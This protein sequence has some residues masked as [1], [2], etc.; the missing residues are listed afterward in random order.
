MGTVLRKFSK[1]APGP[2]T[3]DEMD[4]IEAPALAQAALGP[5]HPIQK[6][7]QETAPEMGRPLPP[8]ALGVPEETP[9]LPA[10]RKQSVIGDLLDFAPSVAMSIGQLAGQGTAETRQMNNSMFRRATEGHEANQ[11]RYEAQQRANARNKQSQAQARANAERQAAIDS[12]NMEAKGLEIQGKKVGLEHQ[13]EA[14]DFTS[15]PNATFRET[16]KVSHPQ[17]WNSLSPE[18]QQTLRLKDAPA[19]ANSLAEVKRKQTVTDKVYVEDQKQQSELRNNTNLQP[20]WGGGGYSQSPAPG[21][22]QTPRQIV[23]QTYG[24]WEAAPAHIRGQA[25]LVQ[26]MNDSKHKDTP[27]AFQGLMDDIR[28]DRNNASTAEGKQA[29]AELAASRGAPPVG[30]EVA[31][32]GAYARTLQDAGGRKRIE[33]A[34]AAVAA[35]DAVRRMR[36]LR[37]KHGVDLFSSAA[38]TEFDTQRNILMGSLNATGNAGVLND[39]ERK[40]WQKL[41]SGMGPSIQDSQRFLGMGDPLAQQL[42]GLE[43]VLE[44]TVNVESGKIGLKHRGKTVPQGGKQA[45]KAASSPSAPSGGMLH[46]EDGSSLPDT[47]Q[48]RK[49]AEDDGLKFEV[50]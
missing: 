44:Q 17:V 50:Q 42:E 8:R 10:P 24:S 41:I 16:L 5:T 33:E 11:L 9:D 21:T 12:Q 7:V 2:L 37:A 13:A 26:R 28:S 22:P 49:L 25:D 30:F 36:E 18:Q 4:P 29:A 1:Q 3:E 35:R 43:N 27:T 20:V 23:E 38:K 6:Y 45:P 14:D 40:G 32:E 46:F 15:A 34:T 47:P 39:G 31:D 19:L 48:N